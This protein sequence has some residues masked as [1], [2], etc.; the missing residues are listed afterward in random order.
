VNIDC[1]LKRLLVLVSL[2]SLCSGGEIS[3][4]QVNIDTIK[5]AWRERQNLLKSGR[6]TWTETRVEKKGWKGQSEGQLDPPSDLEYKRECVFLVDGDKWFYECSA[7]SARVGELTA[8]V[9]ESKTSFNGVLSKTL[10][11]PVKGRRVHQCEVLHTGPKHDDLE[12][13]PMT[14]GFRQPN[15][16]LDFLPGLSVTSQEGVMEGHRCVILE[17][18]NDI[19]GK[20]VLWVDPAE[21][22]LPRRY[23]FVQ[24][25][26][27]L[28]QVDID[29]SSA[30]PAEGRWFPSRW[31]IT[32]RGHDKSLQWVTAGKLL[33]HVINQPLAA[34]QFEIDIPPG[35]IVY[36]DV[37]P[38][39]YIQLANGSIQPFTDD[40]LV[41]MNY[42]DLVAKA[43]QRGLRRFLLI[44]VL[45]GVVLLVAV[46]L[47][48][49]IRNSRRMRAN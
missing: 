44:G 10:Y 36:Q 25:N 1:S 24:G 39:Q 5:N 14:L 18:G 15:K 8:I 27:A 41:T 6:F 40:D 42:D 17:R 3:A 16:L 32:V 43:K 34:D 9:Q 38:K 12:L 45:A 29:Y 11:G 22:F 20:F 28:W 49:K 48:R 19:D 26:S 21:G 46:F 30:T 2:L 13:F 33:Q 37:D 35:S 47:I 4:Q 31:S 7:P 23:L